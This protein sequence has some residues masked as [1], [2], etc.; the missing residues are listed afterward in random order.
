MAGIAFP[1]SLVRSNNATPS[2]SA[3]GLP[4]T[5]RSTAQLMLVL[6]GIMVLVF[7]IIG[8]LVGGVVLLEV[9]VYPLFLG[10]FLIVVL[11]VM[12]V[13]M[14]DD[15]LRASA[16]GPPWAFPASRYRGG[17]PWRGA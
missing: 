9:L 2:P 3:Q 4:S 15:A 14:Q 17:G 10:A 1:S 12:G 5:A 16:R 8:L 6:V 11:G 13:P 7:S